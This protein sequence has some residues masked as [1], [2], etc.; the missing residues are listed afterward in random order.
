MNACQR[1]A[2]TIAQSRVELLDPVAVK[3]VLLEAGYDAGDIQEH[4]Y[5]AALVAGAIRRAGDVEDGLRLHAQESAGV[6]GQIDAI[7]ARKTAA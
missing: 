1:M 6:F 3:V 5:S 4:R 7:L 2:V